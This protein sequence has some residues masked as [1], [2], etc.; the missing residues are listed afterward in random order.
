M[1]F[2]A[3][4]LAHVDGVSRSYIY[5]NKKGYRLTMKRIV[6]S[7]TK[8]NFDTLAVAMKK[9]KETGVLKGGVEKLLFGE[10]DIS[11]CTSESSDCEY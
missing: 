11:T 10:D 1:K 9:N 2:T 3:N 7:N 4:D 6:E 8:L 5:V